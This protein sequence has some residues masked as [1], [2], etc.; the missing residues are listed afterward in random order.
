MHLSDEYKVLKMQVK[1]DFKEAKSEYYKNR[2]EEE[3]GNVA[4]MWDLLRQL[5]PKVKSKTNSALVEGELALKDKA[6]NFNNFSANVGKNIYIE[7][8]KQ[9]TDQESTSHNYD[10]DSLMCNSFRPQP[11]DSATIMLEIKHLKNTS[12]YGSDDVSLRFLR[13]SLPE[14]IQFLTC[15]FNISVVTGTFP[16]LWKH[17]IVVP[18]FRTGDANEPKNYRPISLLPI[19]SK[20]LERV[21]A[22]QLVKYLDGNHLLSNTQHGFRSLLS[23]ETALLTLSNKLYENKDNRKISLLTLCDLSKAFDSVNHD[24]LISKLNKLGND[25]FWFSNYL[26]KRSQSVRIKN[27]FS[28]RSE[29]L[30]GVPQGS[31]LALFYFR[32]MSTTSHNIYLAA[33]SFN[34][35]MIN[36]FSTL[37]VLT[38]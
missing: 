8:Q 3:K 10:S 24:I 22:K 16:S 35:R 23:T 13:D 27:Y 33:L 5:V 25:N 7:L 28:D 1:K 31:V 6:D 34:M 12:S 21:I 14:M 29:I 36:N 4:A 19:V 37:A 30:Y 38:I 17:A 18:I 15:I 2:F 26:Y 32:F 20:V 11:T 9:A